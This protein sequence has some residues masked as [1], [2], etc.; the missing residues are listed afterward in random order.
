[1]SMSAFIITVSSIVG[2]TSNEQVFGIAARTVVAAMAGKHSFRYR[3]DP[4]LQCYT[5]SK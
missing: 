2:I 5:V 1:M 3:A 4:D